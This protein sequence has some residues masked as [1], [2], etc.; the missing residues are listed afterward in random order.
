MTNLNVASFWRDKC[1][2]KLLLKLTKQREDPSNKAW[3]EK[4]N[5][6]QNTMKSK[7]VLGNIFK[8]YI[9]KNWKPTTNKIPKHILHIKLVHDNMNSLKDQ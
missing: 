8:T 4:G 7:Q 3:G 6:Q 9:S 5:L 2:W 1:D